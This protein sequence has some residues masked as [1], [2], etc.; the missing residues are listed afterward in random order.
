MSLP[1]INKSNRSQSISHGGNLDNKCDCHVEFQQLKNDMAY[2]RAD[3]MLIKQKLSVTEIR[4]DQIKLLTGSLKELKSDIEQLKCTTSKELKGVSIALERFGSQRSLGISNIKSELK[5]MSEKLKCCETS[6]NNIQLSV[7]RLQSTCAQKRLTKLSPQGNKLCKAEKADSLAKILRATDIQKP[8]SYQNPGSSSV[9]SPSA[10]SIEPSVQQADRATPMHD[11]CSVNVPILYG[12]TDVQRSLVDRHHVEPAGAP[13]SPERVSQPGPANVEPCRAHRAEA[14]DL[15]S[16]SAHD[17][18]YSSTKCIENCTDSNAYSGVTIDNKLVQSGAHSDPVVSACGAGV[19]RVAAPPMAA[20]H[21]PADTEGT[22]NHSAVHAHYTRSGM[23]DI[24]ASDDANEQFT[25]VVLH[26]PPYSM[27]RNDK[28]LIKSNRDVTNI[29]CS[30]NVHSVS[31]QLNSSQQTQNTTVISDCNAVPSA[32]P[33]CAESIHSAPGNIC[34]SPHYNVP[35]PNGSRHSHTIRENV[36]LGQKINTVVAAGRYSK[37]NTS[38]T[39]VG[40]HGNENRDYPYPDMS[41]NVDSDDDFS[42]YVCVPPK[43]YYIGG[44]KPSITEN[45]L[46]NYVT[47]RGPKVSMIRIFRSKRNYGNVVIRLNVEADENCSLIEDAYFWP[48]HVVCRPWVNKGNYS[49]RTNNRYSGF[50]KRAQTFKRN[51]DNSAWPSYVNEY[52]PY[53]LP[54]YGGDD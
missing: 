40:L 48:E 42:E 22:S 20:E 37:S 12:N 25:A 8:M 39:R 41:G 16:G 50:G 52:N 26:S 18:C 15:P 1:R 24:S 19:L 17:F 28:G 11:Q 2:M 6:I 49:N 51:G 29:Q 36:T 23:D 45:K 21:S 3:F 14:L 47:K 32:G 46:Y 13:A 35:V 54:D 34:P 27:H 10:E 7:Q 9:V 33:A 53:L 30:N 4:Q 43:R 38:N 44:F 31:T 5:V